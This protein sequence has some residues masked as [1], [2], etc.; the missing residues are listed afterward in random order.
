MCGTPLISRC[1]Q[2]CLSDTAVQDR[3]RGT[4]RTGSEDGLQACHHPLG[5]TPK[6]ER[7]PH[8]IQQLIRQIQVYWLGLRAFQRILSRH[9]TNHRHL[10]AFVRTMLHRT[11]MRRQERELKD[12]TD[13]TLSSVLLQMP[14]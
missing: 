13:D 10:L 7:N 8:L 11:H 5:G 2:F 1:Q 12:V 9:P 4:K 14:I 3:V 6:R